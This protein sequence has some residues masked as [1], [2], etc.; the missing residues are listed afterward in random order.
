[1]FSKRTLGVFFCLPLTPFILENKYVGRWSL[2]CALR[3]PDIICDREKVVI[4]KSNN[5]SHVGVVRV[6]D[7]IT[8]VNPYDC[9]SVENSNCLGDIIFK[10]TLRSPPKAKVVLLFSINTKRDWSNSKNVEMLPQGGRYKT[11]NNEEDS[12]WNVISSYPISRPM[13]FRNASL[14]QLHFYFL[15]PKRSLLFLNALRVIQ[16]GSRKTSTY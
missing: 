11:E 16:C 1:M 7:E 8:F 13:S 3:T 9:I 10:S 12:L 5:V 2:I 14:D 4:N 6:E 15:Y